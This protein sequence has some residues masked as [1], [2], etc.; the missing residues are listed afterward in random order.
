EDWV[1]EAKKR[2]L[3]NFKSTPEA[4]KA[5]ISKSTLSLYEK[6]SIMNKV[7]VEARYEIEL[8]EYIKKIQIEGRILGDIARNHVI[9]TAITYQNTLIANVKGL[10]DIFGNEFEK[11]ASEQINLIRE[12]SGHISTIISTVDKMTDERKKANK[13]DHADK[14][15]DAYCKNV[16]PLFDKIRYACDKLELLIDDELWPLTKY[17]ELLFVR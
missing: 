16:K 1:N 15:A 8:E 12:I 3:N 10:K 17:R 13:I 7:E 9:P 11:Y 6:H 4:L 2:G 5:Q 14:K